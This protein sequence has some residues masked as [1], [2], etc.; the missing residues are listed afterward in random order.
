[1][2]KEE[3]DK[4]EVEKKIRLAGSPDLGGISL[5]LS[6]GGL[7]R[8]FWIL[9]IGFVG[10]LFWD[11]QGKVNGE[12]FL[13]TSCLLI[14]C[15][16]P[17][18]FWASG[19]VT[20]LPIFPIFTLGFLPTYVSPLWQGTTSLVGVN[21][22]SINLA[23]WTIAGFLAVSTLVW[24]QICVRNTFLPKK[25]LMI[26]KIRSEWILM[27]CIIAQL[28][29]EVGIYF[30]KDL[31]EGIFP[32]IRSFA[33]S[34]GRLGLFIFSYQIGKGKLSPTYKT[35]FIGCVTVILI[36]QIASLLLSTAVPTIGVLFAGY[37]LGKGKIPWL[38]LV[39]TVSG[40]GILQMGKVEMREQYFSGEKEISLLDSGSFFAEWIG[41]GLKNMGM[42]SSTQAKREDVASVKDR[43]S[44]IQLMVKVQEKTPSELPYLEGETYRYIPEM[45]IPRIFNKE[46]AWAHTGNIILSIYYG[47]L[48][49]EN[50]LSTSI[51]F[52]PVIEAYANYGYAGVFVFA[53]F[54][55]I[56][57][58]GKEK[59]G[60]IGF[61]CDELE[62]A[63]A[64]L[65]VT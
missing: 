47:V 1:M 51:A 50:V 23:A 40:L 39:F 25:I 35:L 33:G 4:R 24:H 43:G 58:R 3:R 29:F 18:W 32:V 54:M 44:L 46:K 2:T 17:S 65:P 5:P 7:L 34:A 38:A 45:L 36:R 57:I 41:Y 12:T 15:F 20:G 56:L 55:G 19:R 8:A 16:L 64:D 49:R 61:R 48:E 37:M 9:A 21:I 60:F 27:T 31:G 14:L 30:F 63:I 52:D 26:E 42:G 62:R 6:R 28:V 10:A 11:S 13:V 22:L 59:S 53:V